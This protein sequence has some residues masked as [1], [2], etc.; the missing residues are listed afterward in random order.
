MF[1]AL[2]IVSC[3]NQSHLCRAADSR[4][5][6]KARHALRPQGHRQ[7]QHCAAMVL[8]R[9]LADLS[10]CWCTRCVSGRV[11]P[12]RAARWWQGFAN[13]GGAIPI[14]RRQADHAHSLRNL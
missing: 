14:L 12:N 10:L 7:P 11:A 13:F 3:H 9:V 4:N 2:A 8:L 1:D 6:R 5:A